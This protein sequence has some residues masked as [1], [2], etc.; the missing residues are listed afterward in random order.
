VAGGGG[1]DRIQRIAVL[2]I[3][4]ISGQ[5]E[6]F[7][8]AMHDALTNALS[9]MGTVGVV[10][11]A[12]MMAYKATPKPTRE[13]ANELD[14]DAVIEATVF[15]AGNVMRINVQFEDPMTTRSL[16]SDTYERDVQNVLEA[17]ND[18]VQRIAAAV[19]GVLGVVDTTQSVGDNK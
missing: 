9:R 18:I 8:T 13:I 6:V 17:Q 1:G 16:W 4:D 19:A 15:R 11:R 14:L 10:S 5:D 12:T 3:D 2:P 7:V